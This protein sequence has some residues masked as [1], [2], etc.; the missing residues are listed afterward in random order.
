M[1]ENSGIILRI[2]S[3]E[4]S[5][6][7]P[8]THRMRIEVGPEFGAFVHSPESFVLH[9]LCILKENQYFGSEESLIR[10][11]PGGVSFNRAV[12]SS[13]LRDP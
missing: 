7:F 2:L 5:L 9:P 6:N 11:V 13:A 1:V 12:L 10:K 3:S 4:S 8:L